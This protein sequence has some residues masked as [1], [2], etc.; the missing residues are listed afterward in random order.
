M[1]R[2]VTFEVVIIDELER[3]NY[4]L[5]EVIIEALSGYDIEEV[6][7]NIKEIDDEYE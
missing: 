7:V 2:R 1:K 3:D 4:E 5:E 6:E